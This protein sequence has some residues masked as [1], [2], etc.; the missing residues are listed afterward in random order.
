MMRLTIVIPAYDKE[1]CLPI[2]I[3]ALERGVKVS[4]KIIV[5]DDYSKDRTENA[6]KELSTEYSNIELVRNDLGPG[7]TNALKKSFS[8]IEKGAVVIVMADTCNKPATI[9]VMFKKNQ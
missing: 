7:F 8:C 3:R 5:V 4:H 9:G 6:V 1:V 2:T